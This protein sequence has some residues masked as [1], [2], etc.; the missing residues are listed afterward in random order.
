MFISITMM[1]L[2][3]AIGCTC[4]VYMTIRDRKKWFVDPSSI[5]MWA[6]LT[7]SS[8]TIAIF[9]YVSFVVDILLIIDK[10]VP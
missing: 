6:I 10:G 5:T 1:S 8:S 2:I 7:I 3:A 4:V 9:L